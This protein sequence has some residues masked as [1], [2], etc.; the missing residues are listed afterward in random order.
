MV[1]WV[2]NSTTGR[3]R[4]HAYVYKPIDRYRKIVIDM[5]MFWLIWIPLEFKLAIVQCKQWWVCYW[6]YV[7]PPMNPSNPLASNHRCSHQEFAAPRR[8]A[9]LQPIDSNWAQ[10]PLPWQLYS[11]C[12]TPPK[13]WCGHTT[14]CEH[15][16][17]LQDATCRISQWS[18]NGVHSMEFKW[19]SPHFNQASRPPPAGG[20]GSPS[21][22]LL[23]VLTLTCMQRR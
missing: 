10:N 1:G 4:R 15:V 22:N 12:L 11:V 5:S 18:S 8:N 19:S 16:I 17:T 9:L 20:A 23:S 6:T 14:R 13:P 7:T 21:V 2:Q 3:Y